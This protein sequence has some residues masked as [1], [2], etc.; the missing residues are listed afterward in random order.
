[1]NANTCASLRIVGALLL[2]VG[3]PLHT[4]AQTMRG[5][6][7][8][9]TGLPL[10]GVTIEV[11]DGTI[12]TTTILSEADGTFTIPDAV[13][14]THVVAHL[15]GFESATVLRPD[16]SRIVLLIARASTTTVVVG[17]TLSPESPVAPL[18]GNTLTTTEIARLP[19]RRLQARES[20][21][22]LPSVIR[23]PDGLMRLSGAR[24]SESPML[25][26]GFDVTDPATGVT[27]ISL[28]YEAVQG[29]EV[30]RDPMTTTYGSLMGALFKMETRAGDQK[31]IGLQGFIPRPRFQNP[32]FGRIEGAFPRF[33]FGGRSAGSRF[34]YFTAVEYNFERITVPDVTQGSGPNTVEKGGSVFGRF[35]IDVS[36]QQQLTIDALIFP[37]RTELQGLSVRRDELAS[38]TISA[39]DTFVGV[40]SRQAF[41]NSTLLTLRAGAL[42]HDSS[43]HQNGSGP[44]R[45]TAAGWRDNWFARVTRTAVRYSLAAALEKTITTSHGTHDFTASTGVRARRLTGSVSEDPVTVDNE[46]GEV[47]R[48][49]RF[50]PASSIAARDWPYEAAVRDLWRV[51]G[52]VQVDAGLRLDG[53]DRYGSLPSARGGVRYALDDAGVTVI[54]AGIGNFV[55]KIPLAVPAFAGYPVRTESVF[56]EATGRTRIAVYQPMVDRLRLPNAFAMTLQ[57]ERQIRPGFDAQVGFTRRRSTRLTT[58]DVPD[59]GGPLVVRSDGRSTYEEL[60]VSARQVWPKNQQL[61]VSY[62][63]SSA[64]GELNDFM[65]LFTGFDQPLLQPGGMSRLSADARHRWLAWGTFNGPRG[66]VV[67]P[68]VEWHSG[69][70]YSVLDSR[71]FYLGEPDQASFPPFMAVDMIAYKTVTYRSR[72]ADVGIQLFN[73]TNHKNPRDVYPVVGASRGGTFTNSVG[74]ILRGF[75]TIKW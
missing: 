9:Q 53:I 37:S 65:T 62:V 14:G 72:A 25:L 1:M 54:K 20:L 70:P 69:F 40:T 23:G 57:I 74:P 32:G 7:V 61:F 67:S 50:G 6:V 49:V 47:V 12:V 10:P 3:W 75:M 66:F 15:E 30:L 28:A 56:D 43:I 51:N 63:H 44:A 42:S 35:D 19:N 26:D 39:V 4:I 22:L 48:S 34:R 27:S 18:L 41:G 64:R 24:P 68:V 31:Q 13:R 2:L 21:P 60:Q 16:V 55:G 29:V 5:E 45:L 58:L 52:R 36:P 46:R 38:P 59:T 73:L 8:D 71:Y 11:L 33:F 17:S